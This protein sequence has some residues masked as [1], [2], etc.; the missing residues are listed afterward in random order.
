MRPLQIYASLC[1]TYMRPLQ[2]Y[3]SLCLTYMR[4]LQIY[5]SLCLTFMRPLQIYASLCC[6]TNHIYQPHR[7]CRIWHKVNFWAEFNRFQFRVFLLLGRRTQSVLLFAH[8]WRENSWIH[9][10]PKGISEMQS[11][12]SRIWTRIVVSISY[13][14]N[15]YTTGTSTCMLQYILRKH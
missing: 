4:P 8:S 1:L 13:D 7:T 3:A 9:T 15:H 11:V 10:F 5:A 12:W 6:N 14:D 2:I